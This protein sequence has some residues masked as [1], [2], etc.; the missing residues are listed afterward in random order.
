MIESVIAY[1]NNRLTLLDYFSDVKGLCEIIEGEDSSFPAYYQSNGQ[2][3]HIDNITNYETGIAYHRKTGDVITEE[4]EG[5]AVTGC[6]VFIRKTY[7]LRTV[8]FVSKDV[9]GTNNNDAYIKSKLISNIENILYTVN[10]KTLSQALKADSVSIRVKSSSDNPYSIFS[11]EFSG[12]DFAIPFEYALIAIDYDIIIEATESCFENYTCEGTEI[13]N[14]CQSFVKNSDES[15]DETLS[16]G[17]TYN[18]PDGVIKANDGTTLITKPGGTTK[19]LTEDE[20]EDIKD[21]LCPE[22]IQLT[23]DGQSGVV[24]AKSYG[25]L[26]NVNVSGDI[27]GWQLLSDVSGDMQFDLKIGSLSIIGSGNKPK[28]VNQ[29]SRSESVSGWDDPSIGINDD[30]EFILESS[31]AVKYATLKLFIN[32]NP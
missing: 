1:I 23:L 24:T 7:P 26:D 5:E 13:P 31:I 9:L 4:G 17:H 22:F 12:I 28:L 16:H 3:L 11:Q 20:E 32:K 10:D 19:V 30:L 27:V 15:I 14:F 18:I 25:T 2:Y 8:I 21:I 6:D 29:S